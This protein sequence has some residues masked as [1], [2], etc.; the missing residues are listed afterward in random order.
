MMWV[1]MHLIDLK[2]VMLISEM[3]GN[4]FEPI[5]ENEGFKTK[6]LHIKNEMREG[7]KTK[8]PHIKIEM[9][10]GCGETKCPH[11]GNSITAHSTV[12]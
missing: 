3:V 5:Y 12:C 8:C 9:R 11:H 1:L 7:F 2:Y 10:E 6:C 4:K